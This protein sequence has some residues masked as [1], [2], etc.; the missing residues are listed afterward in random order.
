MQA[1]IKTGGKQYKVS[2]GQKIL[3]EKLDMQ[4][5]SEVQFDVMALCGDNPQIG[6]PFI[7]GAKV[8]AKVLDQQKGDKV[9]VSKYKRRKGYHKTQGHR[10]LLTKIEITDIKS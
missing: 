5:G 4:T 3:I 7:Q 1:V 6:Q 8:V 10:Q 9:V 2:K